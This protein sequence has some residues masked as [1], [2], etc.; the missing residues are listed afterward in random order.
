MSTARP[1]PDEL[2]EFLAG[3]LSGADAQR[4]ETVLAND[5]E[6]LAELERSA[7]ARE[8]CE[9]LEL[10]ADG[11]GSGNDP[12]LTGVIKKLKAGEFTL[13]GI[14]EQVRR[15]LDVPIAD[16]AP[17]RLGKFEVIELIAAGG[18]GLVFRARDPV[19]QRDVAIKT[20]SSRLS[21]DEESRERFLCEARAV[22]DLEHANIL[23]I[24]AVEE[25]EH[26]PF[27]VMPLVGRTLQDLV[28]EEGAL[29]EGRAVALIAQA[30]AALADAHAKGIVHRDIKPANLLLD[31]TAE[32]VF[33][34][35]FGISQRLGGGGGEGGRITDT[36]GAGTP[37]FAAPEQI[38]GEE[39]SVQSDL[40]ALGATLYFALTGKV[41]VHGA[42]FEV[43]GAKWLGKLVADLLQPEAAQRPKSAGMVIRRIRSGQQGSPLCRVAV[44]LG[45]LLVP[46][47]LATWAAFTP[48]GVIGWANRAI[49]WGNGERF[50]VDGRLGTFA[51]LGEAA[52]A[53]RGRVVMVDFDGERA[54]TPV[55]YGMPDP[56]TVRAAPSRRPVL[57]QVEVA[58]PM[59]LSQAPLTLEGLTLV[60]RPTEEKAKPL[61]SMLDG[62]L[63]MRR[64]CVVVLGDGVK[65][66]PAVKLQGAAPTVSVLECVIFSGQSP[67]LSRNWL[68]GES[69]EDL[70]QRADV[71]VSRSLI[72]GTSLTVR[73]NADLTLGAR[74]EGSTVIGYRLIDLW[75][76]HRLEVASSECVFGIGN[77][78]VWMRASPGGA[79]SH[80]VSWEAERN[81]YTTPPPNH[82]FMRWGKA[83]NA[84]PYDTPE[85]W[86]QPGLFNVSETEPT[87]ILLDVVP[88]GSQTLPELRAALA[89]WEATNR[90]SLENAA[91]R[92]ADVASLLREILWTTG[93]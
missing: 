82:G 19:L 35:D 67:W 72:I 90:E 89:D 56:L 18:M 74:F 81:A 85:K 86:S 64:C 33:V 59:L 78:M 53:S 16:D 9:N 14:E 12:H 34:A 2:R 69:E 29:A 79:S 41:P 30:A 43:K 83:A 46:A 52:A 80:L 36:P 31:E 77:T 54:V 21:G 50:F 93:K 1:S 7:G 51:T 25:G 17:G 71:A 10:V 24:H 57:V 84:R 87:S 62:S 60:R 73:G 15:V 58:T 75:S 49:G 88:L 68:E 65:L 5:P 48:L 4:I 40:Y 44:V 55:K 11:L 91:P 92:G 27:I 45:L 61:I 26:V 23:P 13:V 32:R 63:L 39:A 76:E 3:R 66:L 28:E 47:A 37:A 8:F 22:A 70:P 42:G 20:L 38:A 6:A